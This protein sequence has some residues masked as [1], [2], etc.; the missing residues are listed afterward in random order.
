MR[1]RFLNLRRLHPRLRA[2]GLHHYEPRIA[3]QL[4]RID[5][6][7]YDLPFLNARRLHARLLNARR[8]LGGLHLGRRLRVPHFEARRFELVNAPL[9][10]GDRLR[11]RIG[12][13]ARL[14]AWRPI[15]ALAAVAP[16]AA[17]APSLIAVALG[18]R[19]L[20]LGVLFLLLSRTLLLLLRRTL[21]LLRAL[22]LAASVPL[23]ATRL[24][25]LAALLATL[26]AVA[27]LLEPS[28]LLA[29]AAAAAL[30]TLV[31]AA[32]IAALLVAPLLV[33]A[34]LALR[35]RRLDR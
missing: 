35:L 19:L 27:T 21:L 14:A 32:P 9:L 17:A 34:R 22:F 8:R 33:T 6:W 29:I 16:V 7:F 31:A 26:L 23:F 5:A 1:L 4:L 11:L 3:Q 25:T 30:P 10:L 15:C 12:L 28:V 24:T 2:V 20:L 13:A 18:T